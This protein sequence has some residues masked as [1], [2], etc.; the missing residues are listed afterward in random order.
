MRNCLP[1]LGEQWTSSKKGTRAQITQ[2]IRTRWKRLPPPYAYIAIVQESCCTCGH[3]GAPTPDPAHAAV[4]FLRICAESTHTT[5]AFKGLF[6]AYSFFFN[7]HITRRSDNLRGGSECGP[8][9]GHMTSRK[10][11]SSSSFIFW[12]ENRACH[13]PPLD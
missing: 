13:T 12:M 11:S 8:L 4:M 10:G 9:A 3:K 6:V 7:T 2:K 5:A 1:C